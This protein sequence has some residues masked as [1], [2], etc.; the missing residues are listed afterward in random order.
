MLNKCKFFRETLN[1]YLI[2]TGTQADSK[3]QNLSANCSLKNRART[4]SS[5]QVTSR[6][7]C[8][9]QQT[10]FFIFNVP[11]KN[12]QNKIK[13]YHTGTTITLREIGSINFFLSSQESGSYCT[14]QKNSK[15]GFKSET[16]ITRDTNDYTSVTCKF[17]MR[18]KV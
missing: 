3:T 8:I 6:K 12:K 2:H 15:Y 7:A 9:D 17:R 13:N 10:I 1:G 16:E 4:S 14:S 5:I 11:H 18:D